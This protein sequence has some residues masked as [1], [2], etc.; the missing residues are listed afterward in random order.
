MLAPVRRSNRTCGFPASGFH[1]DASVTRCQGRN[2]RNKINEPVLVVK[3]GSWQRLPARTSPPAVAVRPE[4]LND[5][6]VEMVEELADMSLAVMQTPATN[7]RIDLSDQLLCT[8]R[9]FPPSAS[10]NLILE[11]LDRFLT[12]DRVPRG[13]DFEICFLSHRLASR[14]GDPF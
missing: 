6:T 13:S 11:V 9:S 10:T 7:D 14:R 4:T 8:D 5:P 3:L 12:R 1:K 2:Q